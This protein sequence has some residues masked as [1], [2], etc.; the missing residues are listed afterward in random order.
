VPLPGGGVLDLDQQRQAF[1]PL[2]SG[3]RNNTRITLLGH[4]NSTAPLYATNSS[5]YFAEQGEWPLVAMFAVLLIL[6]LIS[7]R[8]LICLRQSISPMSRPYKQ[9]DQ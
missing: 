3:G 8:Y 4:H 5:G 1:T 2:S 9:E 6:A 7:L